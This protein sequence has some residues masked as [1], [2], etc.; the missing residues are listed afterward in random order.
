MKCPFCSCAEIKVVDSRSAEDGGSIRRRRECQ[1]CHKRFTTYEY[2]ETLPITVLKRDG[3]Y[4]GFEPKKILAG[5]MR[6]C[7][8]RQVS[9]ATQ[10]AIVQDI[11]QT[12]Q[13]QMAREI[14]S[15]AIGEMV[16]EHLRKTDE[17]AYV[18]FAS[19]YRKYQDIDSFFDEIQTLRQRAREEEAA[20]R[21][22]EDSCPTEYVEA[23]EKKCD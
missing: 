22:G 7:E 9:F 18:R 16:L 2:I 20:A 5:I 17:V 21:A 15:V 13:N 1:N 4:E 19:V 12:L 10:E 6:A 23:E 3:T 11:Q 8:K 14:S